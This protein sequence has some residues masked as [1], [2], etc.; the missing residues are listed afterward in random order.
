MSFFEDSPSRCV[1]SNLSNSFVVEDGH[2]RIY[3]LK[4][5]GLKKFPI[6]VSWADFYMYRNYRHES[7]RSI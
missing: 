6:V 5:K 7:K 1:W 2:H 4:Q 3:Y